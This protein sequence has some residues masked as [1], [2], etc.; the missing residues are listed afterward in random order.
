MNCKNNIKFGTKNL[1]II[2]LYSY[3]TEKNVTIQVQYIAIARIKVNSSEADSL[4]KYVMK[5][6][7]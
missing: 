3:N 1:K 5:E 4:E 2:S 7:R 6:F